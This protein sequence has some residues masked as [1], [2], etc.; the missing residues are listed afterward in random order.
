[1]RVAEILEAE[2]RRRGLPERTVAALLDAAYGYRVRNTTYRK[3]V[4]VSDALSSRDLG[5]L[6]NA[7]LLVPHG[8]K[9]GRYYVAGDWLRQQREKTDLPRVQTDPFASGR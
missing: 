4:E 3:A 6:A 7:E 1:L 2:V 8:A 5:A 9:R